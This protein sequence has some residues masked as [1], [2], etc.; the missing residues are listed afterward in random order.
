MK[1]LIIVLIL[2]GSVA[3]GKTRQEKMTEFRKKAM[4]LDQKWKDNKCRSIPS[5]N[6]V[7][8]LKD[9]A[10]EISDFY[11][12]AYQKFSDTAIL[13]TTETQFEKTGSVYMDLHVEYIKTEKITLKNGFKRDTPIFKESKACKEIND[14]IKSLKESFGL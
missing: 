10:Y 12:N 14:Q 9:D 3:W 8:K 1:T 13:F 2:I 6:V 4:P 7:Q 11:L 5:F